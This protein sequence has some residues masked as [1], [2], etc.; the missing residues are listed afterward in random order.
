MIEGLPL[1][2]AIV[3][4]SEFVA[5]EADSPAQHPVW[6]A[7]SLTGHHPA[8]GTV[9]RPR[10][11]AKP[12]RLRPRSSAPRSCGLRLQMARATFRAWQLR[13]HA[14]SMRDVQRSVAGHGF[15][16]ASRARPSARSSRAMCDQWSGRAGLAPRVRKSGW[17]AGWV[18]LRCSSLGQSCS[19]GATQHSLHSDEA[20]VATVFDNDSGNRG[21]R[22]PQPSLRSA[23]PVSFTVSALKSA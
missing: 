3:T 21:G 12:A 8:K 23:S 9:P 22:R 13:G 6:T 20:T 7:F 18:R 11:I 4:S 5:S 17:H 19:R 15:P 2:V 14:T 10:S 16:N 1:S